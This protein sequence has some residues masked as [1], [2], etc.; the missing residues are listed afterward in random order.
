MQQQVPL[1]DGLYSLE[2][3]VTP[4]GSQQKIAVVVDGP[5]S[6]LRASGRGAAPPTAAAVLRGRI[7]ME[8]LGAVVLLR[9][10][11]WEVLAM[12]DREGFLQA[13]LASV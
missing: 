7:L 4:P 1:L 10:S 2:L 6:F 13:K 12:R 3:L 11:E 8:V 5:G 9:E